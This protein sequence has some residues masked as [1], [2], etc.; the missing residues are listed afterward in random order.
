MVRSNYLYYPLWNVINISLNTE[1]VK[2]TIRLFLLRKQFKESMTKTFVN[3]LH[4]TRVLGP[5]ASEILISDRTVSWHVLTQFVFTFSSLYF[6][7]SQVFRNHLRFLPA[8]LSPSS[9]FQKEEEDWT[10]T[11]RIIPIVSRGQSFGLGGW[12][13]SLEAGGADGCPWCHRSIRSNGKFYV[14]YILPQV[15]KIQHLPFMSSS[16]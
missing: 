11:S 7:P 16:N 1:L 10:I 9:P 5:P 14:T 3:S 8:L 6:A 12:R 4:P 15:K 2:R 13:S